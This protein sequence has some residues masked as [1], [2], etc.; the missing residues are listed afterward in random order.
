MKLRLDGTLQHYLK[1]DA[2]IVRDA[3]EEIKKAKE[4]YRPEMLLEVVQEECIKAV[5][6]RKTLK[7]C[8]R[9]IID[10]IFKELDTKEDEIYLDEGYQ[11]TVSNILKTLELVNWDVTDEQFT[12]IIAPMLKRKDYKLNIIADKL[13]NM[14]KLEIANLCRE[15]AVN[16]EIE[17][18]R[19]LL[20]AII[21]YIETDD[22]KVI[23]GDPVVYKYSSYEEIYLLAKELGFDVDGMDKELDSNNI[24]ID[25][26]AF[27]KRKISVEAGFEVEEVI[28][29]FTKLEKEEK[30]KEEIEIEKA[31]GLI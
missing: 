8:M 28:F 30:S 22:L 16:K 11:T 21:Q 5:S 19:I 9:I 26:E 20:N 13:I 31:F 6:E 25:P 1:R 27:I 18:T 3:R 29:D 15:N 23:G 4:M 7:D 2:K 10:R 14:E 12:K 17:H 24:L